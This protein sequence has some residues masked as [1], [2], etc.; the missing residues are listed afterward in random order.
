MSSSLQQDAVTLVREISELGV[1]LWE[2]GGQ[3]RFRA[4]RG[5]VT[6]ELRARLREHRTVLVE[7][8]RD[9]RP[10]IVPDPD[11]A[12]EPFPLTDVQSAYLL[13]RRD[14]FG[15][16]GV[17]CHAYLEAAFADLDPQRLQDAWRALVARHG[18]LRAVVHPDGHQQVL[19]EVPDYDIAVADLRGADPDAVTDA[20]ERT[21]AE[22]DHRVHPT[23]RW[24]L[25][26]LRVTRSDEQALLHLSIDLL[27]ADYASVQ[28]LL[29]ELDQLYRDPGRALPPVEIGFRDY[30]LAARGQVGGPVHERDRAY[31]T[32]RIDELQSA[33][34]LPV[35]GSDEPSADSAPRFRRWRAALTP[36]EWA[37]LRERAAEQGIS[38]TGALAAA[39]A[40]V[41]GRWSRNPR[42]TLNLT[43]LGRA[44]LHPQVGALVGDFTSVTLLAV[45][46]DRDT[47]FR[48]RA[49]AVAALLC[50]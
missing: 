26:D 36:A 49:G 6:E 14:A 33:P 37:G 46:Q 40:E 12:S 1:R 2:D 22:L 50:A 44:P 20:V 18:M 48:E 39:Y 3:L 31:W 7:H 41:V 32:A 29:A 17:A 38:P 13:G 35:L 47:T 8:L 10:V 4:P 43:L 42:F 34:E 27:I 16:G 21:R 24:P 45:D 19:P 9:D 25:F 5:V 11:A 30:V 23:D 28:L 15:Y